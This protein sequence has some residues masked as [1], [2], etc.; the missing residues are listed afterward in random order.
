MT[1]LPI[2]ECLS[3]YLTSRDTVFLFGMKKCSLKLFTERFKNVIAVEMD[4][5]NRYQTMKENTNLSP[6]VNLYCA[7]GYQPAIN[8]LNKVYNQTKLSCIF[9]DGCSVENRWRCINESFSKTDVIIT[10]DT[11]KNWCHW[12]LVKK[13]PHFI[14]IDIKQYNPWTSVLTCNHDVIRYLVK[15]FPTSYT[16]RD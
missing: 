9:V 1:Y 14:W 2:L 10:H 11:E 8:I 13:P 15:Q 16:L 4:D 5:A 12:N 3:N 6:H 7:I